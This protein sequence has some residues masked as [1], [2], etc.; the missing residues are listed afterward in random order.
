MPQGDAVDS[1]PGAAKT[2]AQLQ[3][4]SFGHAGDSARLPRQERLAPAAHDNYAARAAEACT[5]ERQEF[6]AKNNRAN[7]CDSFD[8]HATAFRKQDAS[9]VQRARSEL[10][11]LFGEASPADDSDKNRNTPLSEADAA[12]AKLNRLFGDED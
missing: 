7:F 9:D 8:P 11:E 6:V 5:E 10:A 2:L 12:L 3:H 1:G 4:G